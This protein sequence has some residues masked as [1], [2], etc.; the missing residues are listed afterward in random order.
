ME[1]L[2]SCGY[3][4][5]RRRLLLTD[6]RKTGRILQIRK[7]T[8]NKWGEDSQERQE[9]GDKGRRGAKVLLKDGGGVS[10]N[11][12]RR[13]DNTG[14]WI[15]SFRGIYASQRERAGNPAEEKVTSVE[16]RK[17][18]NGIPDSWKTHFSSFF[19][20]FVKQLPHF[21]TWCNSQLPAPTL[22]ASRAHG[23]SVRRESRR[24]Y[25]AK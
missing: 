18:F 4:L 15:V 12:E 24:K 11:E 13:R 9:G 20:L 1:F 25:L 17:L 7:D 10:D 2:F 8:E 23:R 5:R 14:A 22:F 21:A 16:K 3:T 19:F 6:G